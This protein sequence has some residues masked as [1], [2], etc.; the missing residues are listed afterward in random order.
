MNKTEAYVATASKMQDTLRAASLNL[1]QIEGC[2]GGSSK[3]AE[4][5]GKIIVAMRKTLDTLRC[6]LERFHVEIAQK[7]TEADLDYVIDTGED[8]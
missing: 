4:R 2:L 8:E 3:L 1:N 6:D 7:L 5:G